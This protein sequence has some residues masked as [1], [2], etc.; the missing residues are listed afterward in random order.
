MENELGNQLWLGD[1]AAAEDLQRLRSNNVRTGTSD[2]YQVI[3][4][5]SGMMPQYDSTI[6][7]H[8][9]VIRDAKN[10]NIFIHFERVSNWIETG[11][12]RGS[13]LVHC[14]A[15]ASRSATLVIAYLMRSQRLT[16]Q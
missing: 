5:T 11:L 15:G 13:V 14:G 8:Q 7:H 16:F 3:S 9:F 6:A 12:Q 2:C 10:A 4:A 1:F